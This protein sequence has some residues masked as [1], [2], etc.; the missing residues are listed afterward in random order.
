MFFLILAGILIVK[1]AQGKTLTLREMFQDILA[2]TNPVVALSRVAEELNVKPAMIFNELMWAANKEL[3]NYFRPG[4]KKIIED[5][6]A[7]LSRGDPENFDEETA[8]RFAELVAELARE[9]EQAQAEQRRR[10]EPPPFD[11]RFRHC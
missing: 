1:F 3:A 7:M 6:E 2:A 4:A 11:P 9:T 10:N 5:L 8:R